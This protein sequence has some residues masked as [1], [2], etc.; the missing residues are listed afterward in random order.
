MWNSWAVTKRLKG[1]TLKIRCHPS[2]DLVCEDE[3]YPAHLGI[4]L[5]GSLG[6]ETNPLFIS[7]FK[8]IEVFLLGLFM[9]Q[10]S[11]H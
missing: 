1:F 5:A 4:C 3:A 10:C 8:D 2:V 7:H 11:L 6:A 9:K